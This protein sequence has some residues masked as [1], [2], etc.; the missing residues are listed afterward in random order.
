MLLDMLMLLDI[1]FSL[2]IRYKNLVL[3]I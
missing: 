1:K 3:Y 2:E